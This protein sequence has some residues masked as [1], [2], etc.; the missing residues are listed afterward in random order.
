MLCIEAFR[1]LSFNSS[2]LAEKDVLIHA[3]RERTLSSRKL[4]YA[5]VYD[6]G[7]AVT[8]SII[9]HVKRGAKRRVPKMT[10]NLKL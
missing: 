8:P 3:I 9:R 10:I 2:P 6:R 4:T 7:G 5:E 1:S